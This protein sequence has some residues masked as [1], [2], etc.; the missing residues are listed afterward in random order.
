MGNALFL[1]ILAGIP[2]AIGLGVVRYRLYDIDVLISKTIVYGGLAV[3]IA[4]AYA[5]GVV[6]VCELVDRWAGSS[7]LLALTATAAVATAFHPLRTRPQ[8]GADR[9]VFGDRAAPYELMT[10]FG[11]ELRQALAT[12]DVLARIAATAAQAARA[13]AARVAATLPNGKMLTESWPAAASPPS[14]DMLV[15]VHHGGTV[16]AEISVAGA[17]ART[18]DVA[19]LQNIA[20]VS[21]AALR[22]LRLLAEIESLHETI[23]RQNLEV[24]A[25]RSRLI[26]A[27]EVERRR[28]DHVV[29]Q[30]LG[31]DL[32][33]LRDTLPTFW[34]DVSMRPDTVVAG[35]ERLAVHATRIVD[36]M[37]DISRGVLPPL[38]ADHGLAVALRALVRRLDL[39]IKL[40]MAPSIITSRFPAPI[41]TTVYLCFQAAIAAARPSPAPSRSLTGPVRTELGEISPSPLGW[42]AG[43]ADTPDPPA[44]RGHGC[45]RRTAGTA[46]PTDLWV[47]GAVTIFTVDGAMIE[48]R[49]S[50]Q[51]E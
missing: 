20:A 24:A 8:S 48:S 11:H 37:R 7:T 25:S 33:L 35:C 43:G 51:L 16:I 9:L 42:R 19:L 30:R 26:A 4:L 44:G 39:D 10:R 38:L 1:L 50:S 31:P 5:V 45:A 15:P 23:Q 27:T 12:P 40:D 17:D 32:D 13:D 18:A 29:A 28:L 46:R 2:V 47:R 41:E 14:F 34:G 49:A 36:E 6:L 22:N 21:A 3:F